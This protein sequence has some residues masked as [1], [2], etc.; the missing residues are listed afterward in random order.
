MPLVTPG[1]YRPIRDRPE[2]PAVVRG[3]TGG[4]RGWWLVDGAVG[5]KDETARRRGVR[6]AATDVTLATA[7]ALGPDRNDNYYL[8]DGN[9]SDWYQL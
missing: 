7:A 2:L 6:A 9:W 8:G 1:P 5:G 3:R 4:R